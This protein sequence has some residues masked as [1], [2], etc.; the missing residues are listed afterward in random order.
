MNSNIATTG[1][2]FQEMSKYTLIVNDCNYKCKN[3]IHVALSRLRTREGIFL[4]CPSDLEKE[5]SVPSTLVDFER[6]TRN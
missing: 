2:K 3:W 1:C 4:V 6:R 5:F